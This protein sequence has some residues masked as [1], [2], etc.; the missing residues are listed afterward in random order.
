MT[1]NLVANLGKT[2]DG[3]HHWF[4]FK[5]ILAC[6]EPDFNTPDTYFQDSKGLY[7]DLVLRSFF[8]EIHQKFTV[9]QHPHRGE[10]AE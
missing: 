5:A 3:S 9:K 10:S 4:Q 1:T 7:R 8:F 6:K 2:E